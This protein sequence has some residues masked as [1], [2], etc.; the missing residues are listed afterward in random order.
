[1]TATRGEAQSVSG[2]QLSHRPAAL[3]DE[4][5]RTRQVT[6]STLRVGD[7][8]LVAAGERDVRATIAPGSNQSVV[9]PWILIW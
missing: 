5:D 6:P 7:T 2:A 8:I 1:M 3:V 9:K 4:A